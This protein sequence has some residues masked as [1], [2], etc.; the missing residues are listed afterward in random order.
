MINI[1]VDSRWTEKAYLS[2][3]QANALQI[4]EEIMSRFGDRAVHLKPLFAKAVEECKQG[5]A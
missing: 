1:S 3:T 4:E 2:F 5:V